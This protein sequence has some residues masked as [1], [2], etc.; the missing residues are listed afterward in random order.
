MELRWL[1]LSFL[2]GL[3]ALVAHLE[4]EAEVRDQED[5]EGREEP[6][7]KP[8]H[9]QPHDGDCPGDAPEDADD[10]HRQFK[11]LEGHYHC[12]SMSLRR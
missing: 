2:L 11:V 7:R 8:C 3:V 6:I 10:D 12:P 9:D 4:A 1:A 5:K